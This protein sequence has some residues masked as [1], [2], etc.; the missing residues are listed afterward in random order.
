MNYYVIAGTFHVVGR[1]PDGDSV[2]FRAKNE[3]HWNLLDGPS[4]RLTKDKLAQLRIEAIDALE[5]HYVAVKKWSQPKKLA[6]AATDRLLEHVGIENAVWTPSRSKVKSADDGT[7]GYIMTTATERYRRPVAFVFSGKSPH[8]NG[9][10]AELG[11]RELRRSVNYRMLLEGMV[12]PTFY[13]TLHYGLRDQLARAA[14]NAR[15]RRRG[16]WAVDRTTN[17]KLGGVKAITEDSVIFPKLF[18]RLIKHYAPGGTNAGLRAYLES[19][20]ES[21]VQLPM[22]HFTTFDQL[23]ETSGSRLKLTAR[24]EHMVFAG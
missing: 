4:V 6:W 19:R 17:L 20:R 13:K 24:P 22:T 14:R 3:S 12:Y 1:S 8:T 10:L 18:R 2:R 7:P 11:T 15:A 16:V 23:I 5:T 21:V 9:S